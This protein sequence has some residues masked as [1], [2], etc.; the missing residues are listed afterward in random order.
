MAPLC[1]GL[2]SADKTNDSIV[3][4]RVFMREIS[5]G[6][7]SSPLRPKASLAHCALSSSALGRTPDSLPPFFLIRSTSCGIGSE[8]RVALQRGGPSRSGIEILAMAVAAG[9]LARPTVAINAMAQ[10]LRRIADS[11]A[12]RARVSSVVGPYDTSTSP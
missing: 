5:A 3:G 9:V 1:S 7:A 6:T 11:L 10:K 2:Q 8:S 4:S 12:S